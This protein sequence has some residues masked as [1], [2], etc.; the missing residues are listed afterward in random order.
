METR[1]RSRPLSQ[2]GE[3]VG[4]QYDECPWLADG[5]TFSSWPRPIENLYDSV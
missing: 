4:M 2:T 3:S 1:T 5:A